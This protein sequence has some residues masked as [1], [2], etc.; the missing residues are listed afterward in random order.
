MQKILGNQQGLKC[1]SCNNALIENCKHE[2]KIKRHFVC[3]KCKKG[4]NILR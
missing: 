3:V 2:T 4:Y 1:L